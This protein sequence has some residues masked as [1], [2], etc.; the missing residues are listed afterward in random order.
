VNK[1]EVKM[2]GEINFHDKKVKVYYNPSNEDKLNII[3]CCWQMRNPDS[4]YTGIIYLNNETGEYHHVFQYN[5]FTKRRK[6]DNVSRVY[7]S[8]MGYVIA[9]K[10]LEFDN[11]GT[12]DMTKEGVSYKEFLKGKLPE[13]I[14]GLGCPMQADQSMCHDVKGFVD[15]CMKLHGGYIGVI[16]KCKYQP[17]KAECWK[18]FKN[19]RN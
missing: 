11:Q 5:E 12:I 13:Y 2:I 16:S 19:E 10:V 15:K 3:D 4:C 8:S 6:K 18:R 7:K 9:P 1:A 14:E 17:N